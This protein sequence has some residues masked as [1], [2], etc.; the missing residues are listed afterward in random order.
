MTLKQKIEGKKKKLNSQYYKT[1]FARNELALHFN[2]SKICKNVVKAYCYY[3]TDD[4]FILVMEKSDDPN[5]FE[6][7]L[8]NVIK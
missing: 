6:D 1:E 2:I 7:M 3:E 5:Y 4:A 8:E